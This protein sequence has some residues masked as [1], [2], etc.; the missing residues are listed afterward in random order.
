MTNQMKLKQTAFL[1]MGLLPLGV[2]AQP[3]N[4]PTIPA[5]ARMPNFVAAPSTPVST[6]MPEIGKLSYSIGMYFARNITNS[7]KRGELTVDNA[8]VIAAITD[9][10]SGKPTRLSEKEVSDVFNQLKVAMQAKRMAKEQEEKAK[11]E[12]FLTQFAKS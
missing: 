5:P 6:E 10:L 3:N 12:A 9:V 2:I 4:Q 7:I 1:I 8:T 11:S